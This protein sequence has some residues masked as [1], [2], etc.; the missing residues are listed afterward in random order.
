MMKYFYIIFL[1]LIVSCTSGKLLNHEFNRK[2]DTTTRPINYQVKKTYMAGSVSAS[3]EFPA[4][5]LNDFM[6][7][8]DSTYQVT[9]SPENVPINESPWYAFQIWSDIPQHIY[10]KLHYTEHEHRYNPKLS[11]NGDTW[12]EMA[13]DL[14]QLDQDSVH[15]TIQLDLT[16]QKL[17]V[18][19]QEI[20]DHRRVGDWM[21]QFKNH[22]SV[23]L[24]SAGT[25]VQDRSLYYMNITNGENKKKPT[26]VVISRQHPP[27]VTGYLAMKAF[28]EKIVED[29]TENGFLDKYRVMVY[30]L[31]NP[32]GVDLGHYRHNT[33]GIDMNRDWSF[34]HQP[35]NRTVAQHIISETNNEKNEV[36]LGLDFHSTYYDVYY[37]NN[38]SVKV[39]IPG[40]TKEW[41]KRL[42][43]DLNLED[44]NE[45][46]SGYGAPTS[47]GWFN[48]QLGAES[49][50]Y[51]IGDD[52]PRDFI[53]VKG[54]LSAVHMMDI[55]LKYGE[56]WKLYK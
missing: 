32:D 14:I 39:R 46:S 31:M 9:I 2:V 52:T 21:G 36:V 10:L 15:A 25:S 7:L 17:W 38:E 49:I 8:N 4:A 34:Y 54:H 56:R 27:E 43:R 6:Q 30:P 47:K 51:E 5:R 23:S 28:I 11:D 40:F 24:G 35:E 16:P 18:A 33:G 42:E 41:L 26:I 20:E 19:G 50:T 13:T 22:P 29:G 3:N 37:T 55:L 45:Q 1:S 44:I 53:K 12:T 48:K